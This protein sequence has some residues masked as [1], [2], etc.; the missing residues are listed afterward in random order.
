MAYRDFEC[1]VKTANNE[2]IATAVNHLSK[3]IKRYGG[4]IPSWYLL[5]LDGREAR[6]TMALHQRAGVLKQNVTLVEKNQQTA[7]RLRH[8][9]PES[10]IIDTTMQKFIN[11]QDFRHGGYNVVYLDWTCTAA[12]NDKEKSPQVALEDLLRRS[13][14]PYVV[15]AQTFNMRGKKMNPEGIERGEDERPG[16]PEWLRGTD[17]LYEE[18]KVFVCKNLAERAMR[19]GYVPLWNLHLESMYR[20]PKSPSWMMFMSVVLWKIPGMT[21]APGWHWELYNNNQVQIKDR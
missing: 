10:T 18:E 3:E 11:S 14:H 17:N 13:D 9:L 15:L 8:L 1:T 7:T 6:T 12:G 19:C 21:E 16:E 2:L 5:A 4:P 20:R